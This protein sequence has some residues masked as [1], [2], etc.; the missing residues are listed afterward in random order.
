MH[1]LIDS[2]D[3]RLTKFKTETR[4]IFERLRKLQLDPKTTASIIDESVDNLA[5]VLNDMA[6]LSRHRPI[7]LTATVELKYVIP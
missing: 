2:A 4:D 7:I 1:C 6:E 5:A 3:P